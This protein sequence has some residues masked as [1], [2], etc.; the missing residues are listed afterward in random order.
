M[1]VVGTA[2][3]IDHGKTTLV[4]ALTGIDTDRLKVEKERGITTECG[5]AWLDLGGGDR[6]SIVDVPG[7]ERFV[8]HMIAG[9]GGID[10]A[11]LVVAA[12][13]GVMPQTREHLDILG[14]IGVTRGIIV[15][16]KRDLVPAEDLDLA[17][18]DVRG[19]L[20]GT[21]LDD[22]PLVTFAAGEPGDADRT[23]EAIVAAIRDLVPTA[24][25]RPLDRPFRMAIDRVF[26]MAGFG[27]VATGTV[28]AGRIAEGDEVEIG[29]SAERCRVRGLQFHGER[30]SEVHAGMR[31]AVNLQGIDRDEVDRGEVLFRPGTLLPSR[32]LD[33][34]FTLLPRVDKP[35]GSR[36]RVM[37]HTGTS[38]AEATLVL[39]DRDVL[40]PGE[41]ALC[42]IATDRPLA[43]LAGDAFVARGYRQLPGYGSTL[44]GGRILDPS[45]ARRKPSDRK[46]V[47]RI[48][49]LADPDPGTRVLALAELSGAQG[50]SMADIL[51]RSDLGQRDVGRAVGPLTAGGRL[52]AVR[53]EGVTRYVGTGFV[54]DLQDD[55]AAALGRLHDAQPFRPAF[56]LE[57]I[58]GAL[59]SP[60]PLRPPLDAIELAIGRMRTAG[61]VEAAPDGVRLP[62]RATAAMRL[63]E[64]TIAR[65]L[66]HFRTARLASPTV[67][68]AAAAMGLPADTGREVAAELVRRGDLV[69]VPGGLLIE[70]SALAEA[71]RRVVEFLRANGTITMPQMKDVLDV[72]RKYSIPIAEWLDGKKVTL[73]MPDSSRKLRM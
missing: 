24:P 23:R 56:P 46:A 17:I 5:Y 20:A 51:A 29:P 14:I 59:P 64:D 70:A 22:A 6:A 57:E 52:L 15:V 16:T 58:R 33:A 36:T 8:R 61:T 4:R 41:S 34:T 72:S 40:R 43:T 65:V 63:G 31:A 13:E 54:A 67:E 62:G 21:F 3:H 73:R 68:E 66:A 60:V 2:G 25:D 1:I 71:E 37:L 18:E 55:L 50:V 38:Q 44:G 53:R 30:V 42:Q 11:L 10:L 12:D 49:Q 28:T 45:A 48:A 26:A 9:A 69:R 7:H 47:E 39:L 27:T 19:A 32:F 35:I